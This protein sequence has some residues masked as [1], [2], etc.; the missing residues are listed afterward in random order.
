MDLR[1]VTKYT[2]YYTAFPCTFI[3]IYYDDSISYKKNVKPMQAELVTI[4]YKVE[5]ECLHLA[6]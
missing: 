6:I 1:R 5:I 4:P 3:Y 2:Y